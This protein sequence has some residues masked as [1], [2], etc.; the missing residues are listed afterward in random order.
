M[1]G[2]VCMCLY[3]CVFVCLF[4]CVCVCVCVISTAQTEWPILMK[5]ST[6]D[7]EDI[8]QWFYN[9]F[10][11]SKS[12]TIITLWRPFCTFSFRHSLGRNFALIFFKVWQKVQNYLSMYA[13]E[14]QQNWSVISANMADSIFE[15]KSN[16]P[17]ILFKS[18][19]QGVDFHL[20]RPAD[21]EFHNISSIRWVV[22]V[23]KMSYLTEYTY[24][25]HRLERSSYLFILLKYF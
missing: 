23:I 12:K 22:S 11:I 14:N 13:I 20:F 2:W 16:W 5:L 15:K 18:G 1:C 24:N 19:T 8:C 4:V 9:G 25:L 3:V 7:L 17:P 6:N 10:E 21:H